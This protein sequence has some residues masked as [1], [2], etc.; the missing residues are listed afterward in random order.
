M[1]TPQAAPRFTKVAPP[2]EGQCIQFSGGR[3]MVPDQPVIPVFPGDG[4]RHDRVALEGPFTT[5][6]ENLAG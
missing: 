3:L 2:S 6:I 4:I 1:T 5:I